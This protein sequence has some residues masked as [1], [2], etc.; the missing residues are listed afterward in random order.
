MLACGTYYPFKYV[1]S[2]IEGERNPSPGEIGLNAI[3]NVSLPW[4]LILLKL[5]SVSGDAC[6]SPRIKS[7]TCLKR[8]LSKIIAHC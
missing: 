5:I 3:F 1:G 2:H 6:L 7:S 8:D 4:S